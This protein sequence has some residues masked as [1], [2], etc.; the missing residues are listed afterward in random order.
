MLIDKPQTQHALVLFSNTGDV[1]LS[2]NLSWVSSQTSAWSIS[3]SNYGQL[4]P[5]QGFEQVK[6]L[7][8]STLLQARTTPYTMHF[9]L[10]S[11]SPTPTPAPETS[12]VALVVHAIISATPDAAR[13]NVTITRA[14]RQGMVASSTIEFDVVPIDS[15]GQI[16]LDASDV[17]Y[18]AKLV[19]IKTAAVVA[20]T[21]SYD[22]TSDAHRGGCSPP[23]LVAGEFEIEVR[24]VDG[25]L[26][27]GQTQPF[28]IERC[29]V[30]YFL[31]NADSMC[32]CAAGSYDKGSECAK[33]AEGTV[34]ADAGTVE[35]DACPARKTS[36]PFR[37][38]CECE[39]GYFLENE[40]CSFCP[41]KVSCAWNSTIA[42]WVLEP[43]VWR[44]DLLSPDL[45]T[46]RFGATSCPG[47]T[48][49]TENCTARGFG[50]WDYCGCGYVGPICAACAP[51]YFLSWA[52]AECEHCGSRDSHTPSIVFGSVLVFFVMVIGAIIYATQA[53]FATLACVSRVKELY[54]IGSNKGNILFFL[55]QVIASYSSISS[56]TGSKGHPE[57]AATFAGALGATNVAFLQFVP[58]SC[59]VSAGMDF[60]WSMCLTA[61]VPPCV[62][63]VLWLWPLSCIARRVPHEIATRTAAGL[64]LLGLEVI[65]PAVATTVLQTFVCDKYDNGW[66]L[67]AELTL[68]CDDGQRRQKWLVFSGLCVAIYPVGVPL[69]LFSLL[70]GHRNTIDH[71]QQALRQ[72]DED[73]S[74]TAYVTARE[75]ANQFSAK[76][77][78]SSIVVS[79][80]EKLVWIVDKFEEF[81]P[82]RWYMRVFL[83]VLRLLQ[84]SV[85]VLIPTQNL[86]VR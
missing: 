22:A 63:L 84:T 50:D 82:D 55:C 65:A 11:S 47:T 33:C 54:A 30:T 14:A 41:N 68:P 29:P 12:S 73:T 75:L 10:N 62:V 49:T 40:E 78:R 4:V 28:Q 58:M 15:T 8:N 44:S 77:R 48:T 59:I 45:R 38:R 53:A 37:I 83:L 6:L 60:Y 51:E 36:D 86:Q 32:K 27:G 17:A 3:P 56:G 81:Q 52:G 70:Y 67:R 35:C 2:W 66:F 16:I 7:L 79:V 42:D 39:E 13:S 43:G 71:V 34:A 61:I 20:C 18:S 31:D 46:C 1:L 19:V 5:S 9:V 25:Q 21:V 80:R 85:L 72:N 24:D 64:T 23:A 69:L 74:N 76:G 26:V 57:P